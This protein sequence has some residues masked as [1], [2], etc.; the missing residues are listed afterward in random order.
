MISKKR[1]AAS[2]KSRYLKL[3]ND[4]ELLARHALQGEH[5]PL[6]VDSVIDSLNRKQ[7]LLLLRML[8][9]E[10][11]SVHGHCRKFWSDANKRRVALRLVSG[12]AL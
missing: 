11:C 7:A 2:I 5:T 3:S 8:G 4:P 9:A 1:Y 12:G 10:S 6:D